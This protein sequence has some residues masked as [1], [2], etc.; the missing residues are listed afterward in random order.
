MASSKDLIDFSRMRLN[1]QQRALVECDPVG[2]TLCTASAGAGKTTTLR[3]RVRW[4][5]A[6]RDQNHQPNSKIL[7][8]A[9]NRSIAQEI[10]EALE[11]E[12]EPSRL[13]RVTVKTFH[14]QATSMLFRFGEAVGLK[15]PFEIHTGWR[16]TQPLLDFAKKNL[17]PGERA[18]P[19]IKGILMVTAYANQRGISLKRA[20]GAIAAKYPKALE[21][22]PFEVLVHWADKLMEFR[23]KSG[24]ISHDDTIALANQLPAACYQQLGYTDLI[25]DELQDLNALQRTLVFNYLK[26]AESFMGLGDENQT[27]AE[28]AGADPLVFKKLEKTAATKGMPFR[29]IPLPLS[30]RCPDNVIDL[31]NYIL[32]HNLKSPMRMEGTGK[33][34]KPLEIQFGGAESLVTYLQ[35]RSVSG[36]AWKDMA[37]L[38][39]ARSHVRDI[40]MAL[41]KAQIPYVLQG[42]SFFE[43][44]P[45]QQILAA[46]R[47]AY[48]P[49][50]D[51]EDWKYLITSFE[52]LGTKTAEVAYDDCR[53]TPWRNPGYAPS[54]VKKRSD[55]AEA[56]WKAHKALCEAFEW[57]QE[58]LVFV[59]Y[60]KDALL[61]TWVRKTEANEEELQETL[62][63]ITS[64]KEWL[65][66]LNTNSGQVILSAVAEQEA[67]SQNSKSSDVDAVTVKTCHSSKGMEWRNVAV[68]NVQEGKFPLVINGEDPAAEFRLMYV[69]FTR[70]KESLCIVATNEAQARSLG[71]IGYALRHHKQVDRMLKGLF[72][73]LDGGVVRL[74]S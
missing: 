42:T 50:P 39:R 64:L 40:E 9:F 67:A 72:D 20:Y 21:G 37:V 48:C 51:L 63:L 3:A 41:S 16:F 10:Q 53:G 55:M 30:Y 52:G 59:D 62:L 2:I 15:T 66:A 54:F 26:H 70:A 58:P 71:V 38:F 22:L 56:W 4:L 12:M 73:D 65:T 5:L 57:A 74:A 44:P 46:F 43:E 61:P 14:G 25:A 28:Y 17:E 31:A 19:D 6:Y 60:L 47:L 11:K 49:H 24:F 32:E 68:Y 1:A 7:V 13:R 69:A 23:C 18:A 36:E 8:M 34:G 27:I 35:Q 29:A 45:I 33:P